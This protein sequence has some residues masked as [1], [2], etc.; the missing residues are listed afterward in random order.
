MSDAINEN[1]YRGRYLGSM[2][3]ARRKCGKVSAMCWD[4]KG[5]E[6]QI[7]KQIAGYIMRGDSVEKVERYENDLMLEWICAKGDVNCTC[8]KT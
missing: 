2:Y 7:V 4:D 3:I 6:K 1:P 5:Y 8:I